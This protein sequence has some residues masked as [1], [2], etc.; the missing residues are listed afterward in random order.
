M[1]NA[2]AV[3]AVLGFL[4]AGGLAGCSDDD[5]AAADD[6]PTGPVGAGKVGVIMPDKTSSPRW[7]TQ[8][9]KYLRKAFETARVPAEIQNAEGDRERFVQIADQMIAG[10]AKV[11]MIT[12]LDSVT[13]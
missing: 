11:L 8:D 13:G 9:A 3:F 6:L 2:L 7:E 12:N 10:G 5:R 4:A 1:R